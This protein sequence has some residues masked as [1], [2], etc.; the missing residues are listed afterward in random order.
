M[1]DKVIYRSNVAYDVRKD[2]AVYNSN[3]AYNTIRGSVEKQQQVTENNHKRVNIPNEAGESNV[4]ANKT[5]FIIL[6]I[7]MVVL[8]LLTLMSA[9]LLVLSY[10]QS[11]S[12]QSTLQTKINKAN[13]DIT[14]VLTQL[15]TIHG[16]MSQIRSEFNTNINALT[17][18]LLQNTDMEPQSN[19]GPGLWY[20]VAHLNMSDPT[21]QCPLCLE[22]V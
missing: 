21:Q 2:N 16:N 11:Q 1:E 14:A 22:G 19:C 7:I 12:E 3:V 17:S 20:R 9:V 15:A 10:N 8:L 6:L 5:C 18:L 13:N 4:S